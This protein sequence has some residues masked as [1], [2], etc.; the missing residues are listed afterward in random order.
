MMFKIYQTGINLGNSG[1]KNKMIFLFILFK[2]IRNYLKLLRMREVSSI[3]YFRLFFLE[4][5]HHFH[6]FVTML[7]NEFVSI[8]TVTK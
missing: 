1:K 5:Y 2:Q 7:I 6:C 3:V 4:I 8:C